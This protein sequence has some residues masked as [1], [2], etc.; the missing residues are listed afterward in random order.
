MLVILR[1]ER[2]KDTLVHM[3]LNSLS[4]EGSKKL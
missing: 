3:H 2:L 4:H 1:G